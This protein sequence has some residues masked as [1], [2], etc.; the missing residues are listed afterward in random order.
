VVY[1]LAVKDGA[2]DGGWRMVDVDVDGDVDGAIVRQ[3]L[4]EQLNN[5]I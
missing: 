3:Q 2:V 1:A 5:S 4:Q